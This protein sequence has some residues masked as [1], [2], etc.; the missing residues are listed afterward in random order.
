M[1]TS[2]TRCLVTHEVA[3]ILGVFVLMIVCHCNVHQKTNS[4]TFSVFCLGE[5]PCGQTPSA[6]ALC[7]VPELHIQLG[8]Q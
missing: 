1:H 3:S 4:L 5:V 7:S 2:Y 8:F 6:E